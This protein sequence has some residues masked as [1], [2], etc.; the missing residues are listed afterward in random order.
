MVK[1]TVVEVPFLSTVGV[2]VSSTQL[3][4]EVVQR[5]FLLP[6]RHCYK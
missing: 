3:H 2:E 6:E 1:G 4:F 5:F